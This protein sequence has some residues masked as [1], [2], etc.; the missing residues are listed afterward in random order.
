MVM[1]GTL[2][3]GDAKKATHQFIALRGFI[4]LSR[5]KMDPI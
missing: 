1:H 5:N 2:R 3:L 4:G